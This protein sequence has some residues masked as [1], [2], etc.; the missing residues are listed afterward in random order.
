MYIYMCT[1]SHLSFSF[2]FSSSIFLLLSN[3]K[4][5]Y[6]VHITSSF[7]IHLSII[8][9]ENQHLEEVFFSSLSSRKMMNERSRKS[10]RFHPSFFSLFRTTTTRSQSFENVYDHIHRKRGKIYH[11]SKY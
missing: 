10:D 8:L 9:C 1:N 11:Y 2:F 3:Y 4:S 5:T 6:D 7:Q